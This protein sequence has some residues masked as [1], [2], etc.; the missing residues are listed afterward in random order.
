[1][2][3]VRVIRNAVLFILLFRMAGTAFGGAIGPFELVIIPLV[4][5]AGMWGVGRLVRLGAR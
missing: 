2:T 5:V 1:V 4:I 3:I